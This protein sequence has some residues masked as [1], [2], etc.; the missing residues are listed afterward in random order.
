MT[1]SYKYTDESS[2]FEPTADDLERVGI[3]RQSHRSAADF[4]FDPKLN[5]DDLDGLDRLKCIPDRELA[6]V[7]YEQFVKLEPW[8]G[9]E[10]AE[11]DRE[12]RKRKAEDKEVARIVPWAQ[13]ALKGEMSLDAKLLAQRV[14]FPEGYVPLNRTMLPALREFARELSELKRKGKA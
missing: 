12:R 10:D 3:V 11:R 2:L 14:L 5:I 1:A 6:Q 8:W 9:T 7:M 4:P 13:K